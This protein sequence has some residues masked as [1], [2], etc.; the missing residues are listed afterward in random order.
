MNE[1]LILQNLEIVAG[2]QELLI[3]RYTSWANILSNFIRI[4]L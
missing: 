1:A 3:T 4:C 2:S